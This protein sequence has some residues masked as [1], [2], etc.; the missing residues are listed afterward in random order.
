MNREKTKVIPNIEENVLE[1]VN[2]Y[3]ICLRKLIQPNK[4]GL[5]AFGEWNYIFRSDIPNS[6]K[7]I[8]YIQS[9]CSSNHDIDIE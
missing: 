9:L 6:L 4:N 8:V 2:N 5:S 3:Y 1:T 7:S